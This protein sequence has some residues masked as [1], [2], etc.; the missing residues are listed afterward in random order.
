[1]DVKDSCWL[2]ITEE[3][4]KS[5]AQLNLGELMKN[6]QF[7]LLEAMSAIE[8]MD[9]K[10]DSGMI[11]NK[12]KRPLLTFEQSIRS[13]AIKINNLEYDELIG[14]I[15]DTY[16]CLTVWFEG[17]P[18]A[19]TIMTN[20]YLHD[21]ERIE[22]KCLRVFSQA[23]LKIVDFIDRL[24]MTIY[25]VEEEDFLV[26]GG[27]FN[28]ASQLNEHKI[29]S[30][31]E[32]LCQHYEKLI[33]NSQQRSTMQNNPSS[34]LA[35]QRANNIEDR[36]L[37]QASTNG[38]TEGEPND[39]VKTKQLAAILTR[40]RFTQ[41]FY[42]FLLN[43]SKNLLKEPNVSGPNYTALVQKAIKTVQ[44]TAINCDQLLEKCLKYLD[45]WK[46][47][48]ELGIKPVPPSDEQ[49]VPSEIYPTIMGFDPLINYKILPPAYPRCT[50][51]KTRPA[52]LNHL[53]DLIVK[54]R[55]CI[56]V[57]KDFYRK[58]F[59]RSL[60]SIEQFSKYFEPK[61]CVISRS[62]MLILYLPARLSDMLR[63]E[64][65]LSLSEYC[66]P[67]IPLIKKDSHK[68]QTIDEF[69]NESVLIFFQ[70]ITLYG[71]NAARQHEKIPELINSFK[72][73][74][75]S[76]FLVNDVLKNNFVYSWTTYYFAK[77]CIKYV[78]AGL[79]LELFSP[80]EYPY[81]FWYL[82][83]IL[84]RNEKSELEYA[85]QLLYECQLASD[86]ASQP[87]KPGQG[88]AKTKG[89]IQKKTKKKTQINT[90]FH[91][92]SL[93][94]NDALR[95]LTGGMFLLTYGL[96]RQGKIKTPSLEFTSEEICFD[97]RFGTITGAPVFPAYKFNLDRLEKLESVYTEA[98]ECFSEAR[99]LFEKYGAGQ[100]GCLTVCK[101]NMVVARL[102]S[103]NS[104][105]FA[106][107]EVEF[108]FD[109]HPSFPT[110]KL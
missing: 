55:E 80:H 36:D 66:E 26:N 59:N 41:N 46:E 17:H 94:L 85:K 87:G 33:A 107:R 2:D 64:L 60:E 40:L 24:V 50:Y 45:T 35:Q 108:C 79:E 110:V 29:L 43:I 78:L 8:L 18:L 71:H 9:P 51:I 103:S 56:V 99:K 70:V 97:H 38:C 16:S 52:A 74:Q 105:S 48:I 82:Y 86:Q 98:Y 44:S 95:F 10:M 20:L 77:L 54:L 1:M 68:S 37:N 47:S 15:D 100:E 93:L 57:S 76:A 14:I 31:L 6:E 73:L 89:A 72:N 30:S 83:D 5:V 101:S 39:P 11:F 106:D 3:F 13:G 65:T 104:N 27:K 23:M 109:R 63:D 32:D 7:T 22:D 4:H 102:L 21:T 88:G 90:S 67:I 61:S 28:L 53:K 92:R 34:Q 96:K 81:V 69:L 58:S 75:Y 49:E 62:F 91:D 12:I 84:Y 25:C 42:A 19:Q